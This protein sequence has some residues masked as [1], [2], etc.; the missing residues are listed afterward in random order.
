MK[1]DTTRRVGKYDNKDVLK[2]LKKYGIEKGDYEIQLGVH[3]DEEKRGVPYLSMVI[4]KRLPKKAEA[5]LQFEI[6]KLDPALAVLFK[7]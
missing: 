3:H 1:T 2:A 7:R 4:F 6:L 5:E